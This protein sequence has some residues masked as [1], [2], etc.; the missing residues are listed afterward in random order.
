M[1]E[2][3]VEE[4]EAPAMEVEQASAWACGSTEKEASFCCPVVEVEQASSWACG[5]GEDVASIL[6]LRRGLSEKVVS[7][8]AL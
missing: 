3:A 8:A 5:S 4:V 6:A 7:R 2:V 1:E